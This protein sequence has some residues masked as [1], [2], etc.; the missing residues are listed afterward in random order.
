MHPAIGRSADFERLS[1]SLEASDGGD[2]G[3]TV[4]AF[5]A[6]IQGLLRKADIG[7]DFEVGDYF[8]SHSTET[9]SGDG[10]GRGT[11]RGDGNRPGG[12][13]RPAG[14]SRSS[15]F[16]F[17]SDATVEEALERIERTK[18]VTRLRESLMSSLS[19]HG[20]RVVFDSARPCLAKE[21]LRLLHQVRAL[22]QDAYAISIPVE[23]MRGHSTETHRAT[24]Y[25]DSPGVDFPTA[26]DSVDALGRV[27]LGQGDPVETWAGVL[28]GVD[29]GRLEMK[30]AEAEARRARVFGLIS[31]LGVQH[32][33][34]ATNLEDSPKF[35]G[36][37]GRLEA[38][39]AGDGDDGDRLRAMAEKQT[40]AALPLQFCD[41]GEV[42]ID[43]ANG[44]LRV[45]IDVGL[46][47]LA[48]A[49]SLHGYKTMR[50]G[51]AREAQAEREHKLMYEARRKLLIH[52]LLRGGVDHDSLLRF[53]G[54][55]LTYQDS[56]AAVT[57]GLII[58]PVASRGEEQGEGDGSREE[59]GHGYALHDEGDIGPW[60][61]CWRA[62][63]E[64]GGRGVRGRVR[65]AI[66]GTGLSVARLFVCLF[67]CCFFIS[68]GIA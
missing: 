45:P 55:L 1:H 53:C 24:F 33:F 63:G 40:Y 14:Y 8:G 50:V 56:L 7:D 6:T 58:R 59:V 57:Q 66:K 38:A 20:V 19:N 15:I 64:K 65:V 46:D 22:A 32:V 29:P 21:E 42:T 67:C 37:L 30:R 60:L 43:E 12:R 48:E 47:D 61:R 44:I 54:T 10:A 41:A 36:L 16:A 11:G 51:R 2:V 3:R 25:L 68:P 52:R 62:Q 18:E 39:L 31:R 49:I 5:V 23:P 9:A 35:E 27:H 26:A 28:S 13:H 17:L 34:A 4:G